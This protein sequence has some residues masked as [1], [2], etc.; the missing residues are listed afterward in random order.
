MAETKGRIKAST[1]S[2]DRSRIET[3][4]KPLIGQFTVR[5]LT[6]ADIERMK[7]DIIAGKTARPRKIEGRGGVETGG[8]G[9]AAR[10]LGM[11]VTIFEYARKSLKLINENPARD[12]KKPP[13]ENSGDS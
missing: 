13:I 9:V 10:T 8:A 5:S 6:N 4:V 7:A 12:V 11:V 3:H 2:S 1:W